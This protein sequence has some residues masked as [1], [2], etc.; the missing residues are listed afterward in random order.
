M[1]LPHSTTA[2]GSQLTSNEST[3]AANPYLCRSF[4][5]GGPCQPPFELKRLSPRERAIASFILAGIEGGEHATR[6]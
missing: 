3:Q 5:I 2:Y 4:G 1:Y 6:H